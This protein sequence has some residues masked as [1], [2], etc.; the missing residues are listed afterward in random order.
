MLLARL[1]W[2]R[3]AGT[4]REEPSRFWPSAELDVGANRL[5][6]VLRCADS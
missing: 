4:A 1:R 2:N 6:Q 3:S 5:R